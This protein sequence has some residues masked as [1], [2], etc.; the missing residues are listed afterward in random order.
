MKKK[1]FQNEE[2]Q[3]VMKDDTEIRKIYNFN[4]DDKKNKNLMFKSSMRNELNFQSYVKNLN[5]QQQNNLELYDLEDEV[6]FNEIE[7]LN[8][9]TWKEKMEFKYLP[10]DKKKAMSIS[11]KY[12]VDKFR[13]NN[14]IP[15][16]DYFFFEIIK[17]LI[18]ISIILSFFSFLKIV[19]SNSLIS[20]ISEFDQIDIKYFFPLWQGLQPKIYWNIL[21]LTPFFI[22]QVFPQ[23]E[24]QMSIQSL[25]N[26]K[27]I[28]LLKKIFWIFE[29][30]E[31]IICV[32]LLLCF[33][34]WIEFKRR[35]QR[36]NEVPQKNI[37]I[38]YFIPKNINFDDE[39][40]FTDTISTE[41]E[42]FSV[43]PTHI[44]PIFKSYKNYLKIESFVKNHTKMISNET[45]SEN[46]SLNF[47]LHKNKLISL[48]K[49]MVILK[50]NH[51]QNLIEIKD[52]NNLN[53]WDY[54]RS[55]IS[56]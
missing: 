7:Y 26:L 41:F 45:F 25:N 43:R 6:E 19:L 54:S 12:S 27:Q 32:I 51:N 16:S 34:I 55:N 18:A 49:E 20:S 21:K 9:F 30:M 29:I 36:Q 37:W 28:K 52:I 39:K 10:P 47:Q 31:I 5:E 1:I 8:W 44:I 3:I 40:S 22:N 17:F 50:Q 33:K 2:D 14:L 11:E 53:L 24:Y 38:E 15:F 23:E 56:R 46:L 42:S 35:K 4:L 13:I 48:D